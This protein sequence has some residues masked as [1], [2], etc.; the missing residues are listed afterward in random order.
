MSPWLVIL[1]ATGFM[2]GP[3][4]ECTLEPTQGTRRAT[5]A[6][7]VTAKMTWSSCTSI[8]KEI[9]FEWPRE[10]G[11]PATSRAA[12]ERAAALLRQWERVTGL[13]VGP[14]GPF[15][16]LSKVLESRAAQPAAYEY[17]DNIPV[18]DN[19]VAGWD[20]VWVTLSSAT[21]RPLLTVHYWANP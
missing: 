2:P 14:F 10:Q 4:R 3:Q 11:V 12:L 5:L 8:V 13:V 6:T 1:I 21:P 16:Q 9:S 19:G 18:T 15:G 17:S 20:G 7:N